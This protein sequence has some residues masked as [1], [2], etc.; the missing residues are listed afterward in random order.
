MT[1]TNGS[2]KRRW[3]HFSLRTLMLLV[4]LSG[5]AMSLWHN[6]P[7]WELAAS[8]PDGAV[9]FSPD[10][11][12]IAI[13]GTI[14]EIRSTVTGELLRTLEG[15]LKAD[16]QAVAKP[17]NRLPVFSLNGEW[18]AGFEEG[19]NPLDRTAFFWRTS[20]WLL[21]H[22]AD[23]WAYDEHSGRLNR[24]GTI[25][26]NAD[27]PVFGFQDPLSE[28]LT[29]NWRGLPQG[30]HPFMSFDVFTR[31]GLGVIVDKRS[32]TTAI[33]PQVR[34]EG[35]DSPM[36]SA[37]GKSFVIYVHGTGTL[38]WHLR[39]PMQWW[40]VACR[41]EFWLTVAL[42]GAYIWSVKRTYPSNGRKIGH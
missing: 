18:L 5:S 21:A 27:G 28:D 41:W 23:G 30:E 2:R 19:R 8:L 39:R 29:N 1:A 15:E 6:W 16:G 35:L 10:G 11:K 14:I 7:A 13:G 9:S 33:L 40:G 36:F 31:S 32:H 24:V 42:T 12:L 20:D 17:R 4:L 22:A 37:D 25:K 3:F 26:L 34:R 38:L